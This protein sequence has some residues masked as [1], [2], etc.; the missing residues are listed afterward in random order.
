MINHFSNHKY[1]PNIKYIYLVFCVSPFSKSL[2]LK[3]HLNGS[4]GSMLNV[5][6]STEGHREHLGLGG[7]LERKQCS[8]K[9]PL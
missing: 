8:I 6:N 2:C 7:I 3:G 4:A 9:I 5:H 1:F